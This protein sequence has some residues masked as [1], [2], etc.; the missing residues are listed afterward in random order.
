MV[1]VGAV[2]VVLVVVG[3]VVVVVGVVVAVV[4]V[5]LV[6]LGTGVVVVVVVTVSGGEV[7][8]VDPPHEAAIS[9]RTNPA[10]SAR[11]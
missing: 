5:V 2:V 7:S 11:H 3:A 10:E 4:A 9:T 8:P 1:V 6:V